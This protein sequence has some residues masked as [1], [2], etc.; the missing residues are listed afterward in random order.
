MSVVEMDAGTDIRIIAGVAGDD[1]VQYS[2]R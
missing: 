2:R 1:V